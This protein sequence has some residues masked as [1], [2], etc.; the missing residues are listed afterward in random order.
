MNIRLCGRASMNTLSGCFEM[1]RKSIECQNPKA[2][3]V[4]P[5]WPKRLNYFEHLIGYQCIRQF[6]TGLSVASH[7]LRVINKWINHRSQS[8]PAENVG[9]VSRGWTNPS[10]RATCRRAQ[11][12]SLF[13]EHQGSSHPR[14]SGQIFFFV[15]KRKTIIHLFNVCFCVSGI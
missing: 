9:A 2:E 7:S 1:K 12:G 10:K 13:P 14:D 15:V 11:L 4:P 5:M 6:Q 8:G 3:N